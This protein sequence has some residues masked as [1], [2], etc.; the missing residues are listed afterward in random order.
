ME[1]NSNGGMKHQEE[2]ENR[3]QRTSKA[4]YSKTEMKSYYADQPL[5]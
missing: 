1:K 4:E 2:Q 5:S 3:E